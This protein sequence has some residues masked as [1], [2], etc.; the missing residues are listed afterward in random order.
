VP[1]MEGS[2][3]R[4]AQVVTLVAGVAVMLPI[5]SGVMPAA[6]QLGESAINVAAE[7]RCPAAT[8]VISRKLQLQPAGHG[9]SGPEHQHQS[10]VH[11]GSALEGGDT[12][13]PAGDLR[14]EGLPVCRSDGHRRDLWWTTSGVLLRLS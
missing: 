8:G 7:T 6:A 5:L 2:V 12:Q 3:R 14:K 13:C 9:G 10:V 1:V 4:L 11:A